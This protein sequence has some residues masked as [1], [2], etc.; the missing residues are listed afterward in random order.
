MF[1]SNRFL[2][3]I[4]MMIMMMVITMVYY[5]SD[6]GDN[7]TMLDFQK[8]PSSD[9]IWSWTSRDFVARSQPRQKRLTPLAKRSTCSKS[10]PMPDTRLN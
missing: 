9:F 7:K 10:K 3:M 5:D 4:K 8:S 1:L 6:D 2:I